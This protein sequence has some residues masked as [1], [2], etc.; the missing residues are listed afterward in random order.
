FPNSSFLRRRLMH[1]AILAGLVAIVFGIV[2]VSI[3][4]RVTTT[5]ESSMG[6]ARLVSI[7]HLPD[8]GNM[9][10]SP[11]QVSAIAALSFDALKERSVYAAETVEVSRLPARMIRDTYPIY[12]SIAVDPVR[13]EVVMQDTNLFGIK[14][15]NRLDN[16][17]PNVDATKP[18]RVIEGP[19]TKNEYNNG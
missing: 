16:T 2:C 19:D 17:P 13:D 5:S 14:V 7:E 10:A 8:Q 1:K 12:S 3:E 9:C 15:F 18:K 6:S 11:E 4:L